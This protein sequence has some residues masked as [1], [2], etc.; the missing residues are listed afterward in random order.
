MCGENVKVIG[1]GCSR[2]PDGELKN[3]NP[4]EIENVIESYI[5]KIQP[6]IVS[7][8]AVHGASGFHDHWVTHAV[9]KRVFRE[10]K[11]ANGYPKRLALFTRM[12]EIDRDGKFRME[13]SDDDEIKYIEKY[14][15]RDRKNFE[16]ALDCYE[17]Y[18]EVIEASSVKKVVN[19]EV[20]FEI[21][22]ESID[23]R[24]QSLEQGL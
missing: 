9:V 2:S 4:I 20:P 12:G 8:Y 7:T 24:L 21:F 5:H 17:A 18:Q 15:G 13:A 1:G 10:M 22:G 3:L 14:S 6:D 23:G 19:N 11:K 16:A